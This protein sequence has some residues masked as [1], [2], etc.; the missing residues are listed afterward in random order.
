MQFMKVEGRA[1]TLRK[2]KAPVKNKLSPV[3]KKKVEVPTEQLRKE[4][5]TSINRFSVVSL[6]QASKEVESYK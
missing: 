6:F 2:V 1:E 5:L 4:E 3:K